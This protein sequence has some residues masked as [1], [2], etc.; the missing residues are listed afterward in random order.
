MSTVSKKI[1]LIGPA[2]TGKTSFMKTFFEKYS[3]ISLL[4][5]PLNPSRGINTSNYYLLDIKLGLF[6]L[7]GQENDLWLSDA[8]KSILNNSNL[9]I[10]IFDILNSV[11][12]IVQF[13]LSVYQIQVELNL[14][15]CRVVAFMNKIDLV[16]NSY[17]KRKIKTIHEFFTK[18]H[19]RGEIF[20][21]F[22]TSITKEH[23]FYTF[24][25][26]LKLLKNIISHKG[27][28]IQKTRFANSIYNT[29]LRLDGVEN[30]LIPIKE[31]A[32]SLNINEAEALSLLKTMQEK[33]IITTLNEINT[34]NLSDSAYFFKF[35]LDHQRDKERE[36]NLEFET[37]YFFYIL[38]EC[39]A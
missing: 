25:V 23:Y 39:N 12:S 27:M 22:Q 3:P 29:F 9:I 1:V 21:I 10:C 30:R 11:E 16:G 14:E 2:G 15:S 28:S 35:G 7:A 8:N 33:R 37:F 36:D 6:D 4:K 38:N 17:V 31:L 26:L 20:E 32:I 34:F 24:K 5:E 19:P 13:L 18:Q